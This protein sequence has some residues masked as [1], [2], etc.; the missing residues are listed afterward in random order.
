MWVKPRSLWAYPVGKRVVRRSLSTVCPAGLSMGRAQ[1]AGRSRSDHPHIHGSVVSAL[2]TGIGRAN[3]TN[4]S[5]IRQTCHAGRLPDRPAIARGSARNAL[6]AAL[7]GPISRIGG[8]RRR[9]E[10]RGRIHACLSL[11]RRWSARPTLDRSEP[12]HPMPRHRAYAMRTVGVFC[13]NG[14]GL[15]KQRGH[16]RSGTVSVAGD[17]TTSGRPS[18]YETRAE[19]GSQ[20]TT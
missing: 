8:N 6:G 19:A 1:R 7:Y 5:S 9:F 12:Y 20:A 15:S 10:K 4:G 2:R 11:G 17:A 13:P 16:Q 3:A 18:G 14:W